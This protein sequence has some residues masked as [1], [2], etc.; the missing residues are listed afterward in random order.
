MLRRLLEQQF[1]D[2]GGQSTKRILQVSVTFSYE[3]DPA[4]TTC[5]S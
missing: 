3:Q 1:P 2:A 5:A 4:G